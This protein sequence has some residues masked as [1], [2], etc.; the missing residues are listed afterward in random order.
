LGL[1]I[2][3]LVYSLLIK[4]NR[5]SGLDMILLGLI[6][7][8]VL[9]ICLGILVVLLHVPLSIALLHQANAL[10]LFVLG[11]ILIHRLGV[12]SAS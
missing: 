6:A 10:A 3:P 1:I 8:V 4:A 5:Q 11:V 7:L 12:R 9:Q 2:I